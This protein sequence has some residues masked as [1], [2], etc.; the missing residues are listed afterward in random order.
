MLRKSKS[1]FLRFVLNLS[2]PEANFKWIWQA[3]EA[4]QDQKKQLQKKKRASK[5]KSAASAAAADEQAE[6]G[7]EGDERDEGEEDEVEV[8]EV[9]E[10]Q[11][12]KSNAADPQ[13]KSHEAEAL[14]PDSDEEAQTKNFASSRVKDTRHMSVL[15]FC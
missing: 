8:E 3:V 15:H 10:E 5:R 6:E 9:V 1:Y 13:L 2:D 7:D 4:E 12:S 14:D 11:E